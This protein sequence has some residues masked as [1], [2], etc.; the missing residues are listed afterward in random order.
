MNM[1]LLLAGIFS[2]FIFSCNKSETS[3]DINH[4]AFSA[5]LKGS[6]E[7]PPNASLASGTASSVYN[8]QTRVLLINVTYSGLTATAAHIHKGAPGVSGPVIF[9]FTSITLPINYTTVAFDSTM[10]AD[11][12]SNLYYVNIHSAAYPGG[13]IRGQLIKQ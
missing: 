8:T 2:V 1:K 11:L 9:G 12:M 13:E 3:P 10:E 4:V 5:T 6:S 7:T